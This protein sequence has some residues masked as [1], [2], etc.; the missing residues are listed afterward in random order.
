MKKMLRRILSFIMLVCIA[1]MGV[2]TMPMVSAKAATVTDTLNLTFTGVEAKTN[3]VSWSGKE[4]VSGAVY[5][6]QNAGDSGTI[7]LRTTNSN[8]GIVTTTSGG[9]AKSMTIT[10]NSK[11]NTARKLDIYGSDT[12]YTQAT[13]LYN[14]NNHT[15]IT[16]VAYSTTP[17][18]VDLADKNGKYY[19]IH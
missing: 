8:S 14:N 10:W 9:K 15:K 4:G 19:D 17:V 18:T 3:Y 13:G 12:A 11:T 7:Q 16:Q 6:G 5:A 2:F 1:F